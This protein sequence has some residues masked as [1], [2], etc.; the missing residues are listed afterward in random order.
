MS[1]GIDSYEAASIARDYWHNEGQYAAK[2]IADEAAQDV[3][4][5][6]RAS[7]DELREQVA[8]LERV[9]ASRTEHLA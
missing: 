4:R 7:V 1:D 2:R 8:S 9:L 6:L 5:E 3:A